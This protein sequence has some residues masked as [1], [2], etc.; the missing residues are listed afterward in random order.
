M[1]AHIASTRPFSGC[2]VLTP[3][4]SQLLHR[5][6]AVKTLQVPRLRRGFKQPVAVQ[7]SELASR[8][9]AS[10]VQQQQVSWCCALALE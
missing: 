1:K 4:A 7:S 3:S 5:G 9:P 2:G 6:S 10:T 8:V